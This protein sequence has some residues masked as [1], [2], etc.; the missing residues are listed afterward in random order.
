MAVTVAAAALLAACSGGSDDAATA[1]T[2][3]TTSRPTTTSAS[4]RPAIRNPPT[5]TAPLPRP[6]EDLADG[7]HA[8]RIADFGDDWLSVDV[9]QW[10]SGKEADDAYAA[11]TGDTSGVPNDYYIRNT[12]PEV[13]TLGVADD[14]EITVA[15]DD[16]GPGEF[17]ATYEELKAAIRERPSSPFW[18]TVDRGTI[19]AIH[20]QY[21]P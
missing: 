13:R 7:V 17:P 4:T 6:G 18:I 16:T 3:S 8:V 15:W 20:E 11:A 14:P 10:L 12:S 1:S 2:T 5:V 19:T 21:T 9:V